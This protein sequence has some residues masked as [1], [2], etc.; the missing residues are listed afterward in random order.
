MSAYEAVILFC[1]S[2][3][4]QAKGSASSFAVVS[5]F[6]VASVFAL[7]PEIG[8]GFSPDITTPP[9]IRL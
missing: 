5:A 7:A 1:L 2:S 4:S 3:G 9:Q 8:L 6:A